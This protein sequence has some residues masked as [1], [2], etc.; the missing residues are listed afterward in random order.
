ME[1][2]IS[3]FGPYFIIH[4][5]NNRVTFDQKFRKNI[6]KILFEVFLFI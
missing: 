4:F 6:K 5:A 3:D 2:K 1:I